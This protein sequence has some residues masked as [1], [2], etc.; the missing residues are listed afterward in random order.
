MKSKRRPREIAA[1]TGSPV[2]TVF[3]PGR[4]LVVI[5]KLIATASAKRERNST[6]LPGTVFASC[7]KTFTLRL[8]AA[9]TG[10]NDE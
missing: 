3:T 9:I 10:G 2:H 8:C 7:R 5:A 1:R 4:C 6:A